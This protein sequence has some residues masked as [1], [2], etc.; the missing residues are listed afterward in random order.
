MAIG[1]EPAS[2][3]LTN[4]RAPA[5]RD[6]TLSPPAVALASP[7][8][9]AGKPG[10]L[11]SWP[12]GSTQ[13]DRRR[14]R[15]TPRGQL[16]RPLFCRVPVARYTN[17]IRSERQIAQRQRSFSPRLSIHQHISISGRRSNQH[18]SCLR[19]ANSAGCGTRRRRAGCIGVRAGAVRCNGA[20][21][22][23]RGVALRGGAE[24]GDRRSFRR[25]RVLLPR[26]ASGSAIAERIQQTARRERRRRETSRRLASGG[27]RPLARLRLAPPAA[28]DT[29]SVEIGAT[30]RDR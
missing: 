28:G 15:R 7:I 25:R 29:S 12:G 18:A 6:C 19:R 1:V 20:Q 23:G 22:R 14:R 11:C 8:A 17:G 30:R 21:V 10:R 26:R 4:T 13:I 2:R 3:S 16:Q 9:L 5:G 27:S 24:A